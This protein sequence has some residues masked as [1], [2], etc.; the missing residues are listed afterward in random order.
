MYYVTLHGID[1][2]TERRVGER[3]RGCGHSHSKGTPY[4]SSIK[5]QEG[6]LGLHTRLYTNGYA[7]GLMQI[8]PQQILK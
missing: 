8:G 2:V 4:T 5:S 7:Y 1:S 3:E 6:N